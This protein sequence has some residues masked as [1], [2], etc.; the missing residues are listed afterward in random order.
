VWFS[1][2]PLHL[3]LEVVDP[4]FIASHCALRKPSPFVLYQQK[5]YW[6]AS[7]HLQ[8]RNCLSWHPHFVELQHVMDGMVSWTMAGVQKDSPFGYCKVRFLPLAM[9]CLHTFKIFT[10]LTL[11]HM[12]CTHSLLQAPISF[13]TP[14]WDV[15][16]FVP[17]EWVI[18]F[19]E[20]FWQRMSLPLLS[21]SS[22][23]YMCRPFISMQHKTHQVPS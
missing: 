12:K 23:W 3:R 18:L 15:S 13:Q 11:I 6:L 5:N 9:F 21:D 22:H 8:F 10:W 14:R 19:I 16:M 1:V 2:C 20:G 4:A 17:K 7:I